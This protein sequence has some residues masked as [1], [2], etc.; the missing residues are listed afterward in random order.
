MD[1]DVTK[2]TA[3]RSEAKRG[4]AKHGEAVARRCTTTD[5]ASKKK[6]LRPGLAAGTPLLQPATPHGQVGPWRVTRYILTLTS[7]HVKAQKGGTR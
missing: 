4:G 2:R 3:G 7:P 6:P 1:R 5:E